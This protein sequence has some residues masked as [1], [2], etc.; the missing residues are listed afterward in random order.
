MVA[1][2]ALTPDQVTVLVTE[3]DPLDPQ[4]APY[5]DLWKIR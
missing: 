2:N 1:T 3:L 4:L 5:H